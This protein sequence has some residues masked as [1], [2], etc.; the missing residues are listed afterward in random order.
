MRLRR[1][2]S[3]ALFAI[4]AVRCGAALPARIDRASVFLQ[5]SFFDLTANSWGR[6]HF[7]ARPANG[8]ER[9]P[10]GFG[11]DRPA[12]VE[13]LHELA[14]HRFELVALVGRLDALG[15]DR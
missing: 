6:A 14:V 5:N 12:E 7:T 13:A 2:G 10:D 3:T 11:V 9:P 15:D 8:C 1:T 4:V